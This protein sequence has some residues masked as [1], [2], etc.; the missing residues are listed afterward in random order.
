MF[1]PK[2]VEQTNYEK[3][4]AILNNQGKIGNTI[5]NLITRLAE[6]Q[7]SWNPYWRNSS[8]KMELIINAVLNLEE[9]SDFASI[10]NDKQSELYTA[11]NMQRLLPVTV[12]G[13]LGF[14]HAKSAIRAENE[15]AKHNDIK[16]SSASII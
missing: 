16:D 8:A 9:G 13:N 4:T 7:N 3:A 10:L 15:L 12:L 14:Y 2:E 1:T 6:N 11:L 5:K